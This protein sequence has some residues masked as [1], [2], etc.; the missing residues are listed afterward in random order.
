MDVLSAVGI[1]ITCLVIAAAIY[2]IV[3]IS[4]LLIVFRLAAAQE[5][6]P[7][8]LDCRDARHLACAGCACSCHPR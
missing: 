4:L 5:G 7:S 2:L 3:G 6:V 1:A 8:S